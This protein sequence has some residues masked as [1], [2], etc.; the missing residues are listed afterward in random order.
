MA[1]VADKIERDQGLR[2]FIRFPEF[3]IKRYS[4][5]SQMREINLNHDNKHEFFFSSSTS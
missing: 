1:M 2:L 4:I 3:S 5:N